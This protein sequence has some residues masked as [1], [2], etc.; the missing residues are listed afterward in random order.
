[1][2]ISPLM[3]L[4][5]PRGR[6]D[7]RRL[8]SRDLADGT[9][10]E[11]LLGSG[12]FCDVYKARTA[13]GG[14]V[15]LKILAHTEA[16]A[17]KRF[18]REAKVLSMLGDNPHVVR[19]LGA[20]EADGRP[21]MKL[22]YVDGYTLRALLD[23]GYVLE[24]G[25]AVVLGR[26]L[27]EAFSQLHALGVAHG[28]VCPSNIMI[29]ADGR[30]AK[31]CDFGLARDGQ[32]LLKLLES[33]G[34]VEGDEFAEEMDKGVLMGTPAYMAPEQIQDA[35]SDETDR[36]H[37]D[38][39]S[40]VYSLG[41]VLYELLSGENPHPFEADALTARKGHQQAIDY[42]RARLDARTAPHRALELPP[43]LWSILET[44]L[45][46]EPRMR[47]ADAREM[48][49]ALAAWAGAH[50]SGFLY[51]GDDYRATEDGMSSVTDA[52]LT[53][54]E[55]LKISML[56]ASASP[57]PQRPSAAPAP[58]PWKR[59]I[60]VFLSVAIGGAAAV[61]LLRSIF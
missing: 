47:Y 26:Q 40:D 33:E 4:F 13:D 45:H 53:D 6:S 24:P 35:L 22:E 29:T 61:A 51:S 20:G 8:E 11:R 30:M 10:V 52:D 56:L 23:S 57:T 34:M 42:C 32:G 1:M 43:G 39:P 27:C 3:A 21:W 25:P 50:A 37:T 9:R 7:P 54:D 31:L 38:T 16:A 2:I 28:D 17:L 18:E 55:N 5:R 44:A 49:S 58:L 41:V 48:G 15:A 36:A 14:R 46:A 60:V 59:L 12:A 19:Y